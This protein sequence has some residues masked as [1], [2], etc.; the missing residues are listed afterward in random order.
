MAVKREVPTIVAE[1]ED[2]KAGLTVGE[3]RGFVK[4]LDDAAVPD[5]APIFV[6][7][8]IKDQAKN[9]RTRRYL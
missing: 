4:A 1:A 7:A 3:V 8:G 5:D 2:Q 6:K 9:L